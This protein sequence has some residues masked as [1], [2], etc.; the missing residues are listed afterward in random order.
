MGANGNEQNNEQDDDLLM[1]NPPVIYTTDEDGNNH[2]F[3]MVDMIE[4][5]NKSYAL[6][7]YLGQDDEQAKQMEESGEE[8]ELVVMRIIQEGDEQVFEMIED[9]AEY[10]KVL[11]YLESEEEEEEEEENAAE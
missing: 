2:Q 7:L 1:E 3:Q 6:L 8:P 11:Q 10:E 4:V 5:D 9:E